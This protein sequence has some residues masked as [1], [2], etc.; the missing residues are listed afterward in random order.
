LGDASRSTTESR[1]YPD[2]PR[3]KRSFAMSAG[4]AGL[5]VILLL[6]FV[7]FYLRIFS[8]EPRI[9]PLS[10]YQG[11]PADTM[12]AAMTVENVARY[13]DEILSFG[14]RFLGQPGF[15]KTED[16]MRRQF[17]EAGLEMHE[18]E[19]RTA[20]PKTFQRDLSLV[21]AL[22]DGSTSESLLARVDL[23]PFLPNHL[24]PMNTPAGGLVGELVVL[25]SETL[26][27]RR[28]FT[29]CIGILDTR[30]GMYDG[31]YNFNW[32]AYARL[33]LKAIILSHPDGLAEAPW[34]LVKNRLA[35]MVSSV[36]VNYV[37]LA[38]SKEIL[39]YVGQRVRLEVKT[40]YVN[41]PNRTIIG[42]MRAPGKS[43]EAM[44]L[45]SFYDARSMLPDMATV[46]MQALMPA[47]QLALLDGL[48]AYRDSLKR[49]LI[50]VTYSGVMADEGPNRIL[51]ILSTNQAQ[52]EE[53]PLLAA[54]GLGGGEQTVEER[55]EGGGRRL[56]PL[57]EKEAANALQ[58]ASL[59]K[60]LQLFDGAGFLQNPAI[61]RAALEELDKETRTFLEEQFSYVL[62]SLVFEHTEPRLRAKV[63][64]E[65][66]PEPDLTGESF[67]RYRNV[68]KEYEQA[69]SV[70]GYSLL[71]L[72]QKK[73]EH[74]QTY[75]V[76]ELF[77]E[78][79]RE[80]RE[81]HELRQTQI[82]QEIDLVKIINEYENIGIFN[83]KLAPAFD[84][85]GTKE[86]LSFDTG[87]YVIG[88]ASVGVMSLL[89]SA[90]QR[91]GIDSAEIDLPPLDRWQHRLVA[92]NVGDVYR[93]ATRMWTEFGYPSYTFVNFERAESYRRYT[94][95]VEL[96]FMFD[97]E[98]LRDSLG[99]LGE[100]ILSMAHG[101]GYLDPTTPRIF[102]NQSWG[103]RVLV[104]NV[105]QSI[106]P[107]YPLAGAVIAARSGPTTGQFA[108]PGYW[109]NLIVFADPY[110]KW[111][112]P[113]NASDFGAWWDIQKEQYNPFAV[114]YDKEGLIYY[115]KD[116]GEDGQRLYKSARVAV[117]SP[118]TIRN[119]TMVTFRCAPVALLDKIN[120]Q[121]MKEYTGTEM[122]NREGLV[123]FR[124]KAKF[125]DLG[126]ELAFIEPDQRL[127]VELQAGVPDNDL[128][129]VT[130]AFMLGINDPERLDPDREID[131]EGY[132]A[133]DTPFLLNVP[134]EIAKSMLS[135]NG[136]RLD[137]QERY[138]MADNRTEIYHE[139][140]Q[141]S[142]EE[143]L[144]PD[145]SYHQSNLEARKA[146]TYA[147]L[148]HPVLRDS[149]FEAIL[150]VL[151]YLALLVPFVFF[152]E[153]LVFCYPD[154]RKQIVA[155]AVIFLTVFILLRLLHPA[156][157]MVR[158]SLMILLGFIIIL[159]SGG[160][161]ILFSGKFQENLEELRK[162][163]GKVA[164]ADVN[165]LG[166]IGS[167]FMLGLNN[168]HRRK[169]R[170][171]LTCATLTL[172]TFVMIC[173]TSVE[174]D[175][176]D[177]KLA[178]GKAPFQGLLVKREMFR[179]ITTAEIFSMRSKYS[180]DYEICRRRAWTGIDNWEEHQRYN[181][182]LEIVFH[183][184][185]N[186][187]VPGEQQTAASRRLEFNS[188]IQLSHAE[189]LRNEIRFL[190][191][192][193]W[194]TREQTEKTEGLA[195]VMIPDKMAEKLGISPEMVDS[196]EPVVTI[197]GR[198][199]AVQGIFDSQAF[200]NLNDLDG[201]NLLPFD[202]V[203]MEQLI[204]ESGTILA[205]PDDPRIAAD[206]VILAPMKDLHM[207]AENSSERDLSVAIAMPDV[208]YKQALEEIEFYMEQSAEPVFYGLD[209]VAYRGRRARETSM[210]GLIDLLIPLIIAALTVL[211]TMRG[212]VYERRDE[213]FV[214]NAVGIAPRYVFFM[215]FTEAFVYAIVGAILGYLLSQGT[216][217]IL[218][219][220][221]MTGG[222]KMTFASLTTIYASLTIMA[223][224]F[225]STYFPARSAMEI[226]APAEESGWSLPEPDEDN[227]EFDLPF[228][229][230][231]RDRIAILAFFDRYL[232]D[233]GEGSAG[234]FFAAEPQ[235]GVAE[236]EGASEYIPCISATVWL[237][238]FDLGVSQDMTIALPTD[239]ETGEYKARI[240][241][242]RVSGTR[243]SWMRL[244]QSFVSLVR[245]H[246]LHWRAV[247]PPERIEMFHEARAD[248]EKATVHA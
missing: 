231:P 60:T 137:L 139:K 197:N 220:L 192:P 8:P 236:T 180:D 50:F 45:T 96:P 130:R 234:R 25:T 77:L 31:D 120:P 144:S 46:P 48:Q 79:L 4:V 126:I 188:I 136:K 62:N 47:C 23:Y 157:Q 176:V 14:G 186:P 103:G 175:L 64:L 242:S 238:P 105:G 112:L 210:A 159:I 196:D 108:W 202:V 200:Q 215:F 44:L 85:T 199:F 117:W 213:I 98:S 19:L 65:R 80:L 55:E 118:Q 49:D 145:L 5:F 21:Q 163:Q 141:K 58:L 174:N 71:N 224:V 244:N 133:S 75:R 223:A 221:G 34:Y 195:P 35:G 106:V 66:D 168:M 171:G 91:L 160:I 166:V 140:S 124:K 17:E 1:L 201:E 3:E 198:D 111:D 181:P 13:R 20:A 212:S 240:I 88:P 243:E 156:F 225:F 99:V 183:P 247:P 68:L 164:A 128:A 116:E 72:L 129:K 70:A 29:D 113:H 143:S 233:H 95:P 109:E 94:D 53:N 179:P 194:F 169:V 248:L 93:Q 41:T 51:S 207:S 209:G 37:R 232:R 104:S 127:Y 237:K 74:L 189:P 187:N 114:A 18:M 125:T 155:Q 10:P 218:T 36:P 30:D 134:Q 190:T 69:V 81:H 154:V 15:Y 84:E 219:E 9:E 97:L 86:V 90:R 92:R 132:L 216:G 78:R 33:G 16:Y 82:A 89:S 205:S 11:Y 122:I 177:E 24:Q 2:T 147:I 161:T 204:L 158:S 6:G 110:G 203:S 184:P 135:V 246:F 59:K 54:F 162:K 148:N 131:G 153:K 228:T 245:Q 208:T 101:N 193:N 173:F 63:N 222:M 172:L 43:K 150:G 185:Q 165:T 27:M 241:L 73:P 26:R 142:L 32:I 170:T 40:R 229:F 226:S 121:S 22:P 206:Q 149:I 7:F 67:Q 230:T 42:I 178:L 151:W 115:I 83:T 87:Q 38:A 28:S 191:R 57:L 102:K 12:Q 56:E 227:L 76:R 152:F 235:V 138:G 61:T 146:V 239:P 217:R 182:S 52:G 211:N 119:V 214:Y 167:A 39:D 100:G 123:D 107:S